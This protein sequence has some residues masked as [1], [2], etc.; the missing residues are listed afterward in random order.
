MPRLLFAAVGSLVQAGTSGR[1]EDTARLPRRSTEEPHRP[2]RLGQRAVFDYWLPRPLPGRL[3]SLTSYAGG[4]S[5][6]KTCSGQRLPK[7]HSGQLAHRIH[8]ASLPSRTTK[9]KSALNVGGFGMSSVKQLG[10][11]ELHKPE[12]LPRSE[13]HQ[14][15]F[16]LNHQLTEAPVDGNFAPLRD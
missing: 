5:L 3:R 8:G 2:S 6:K 16:R 9:P 7:R 10:R 12:A 14:W 13:R 15:C 1:S 11:Q 4:K